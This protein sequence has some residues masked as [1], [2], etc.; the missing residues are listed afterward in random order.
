MRRQ[1]RRQGR[2]RRRACAD[3][4]GC[5]PRASSPRPTCAPARSLE[6]GRSRRQEAGDGHPAARLPDARRPTAAPRRRGRRPA[7]RA[8]TWSTRG[9]AD[10]RR[11]V[12]VVVTA[13][14]SYSRIKTALHGD[15]TSTRTSSCSS[16]SRASA[17]LDRYGSAVEH[18]AD[19]RLR[20]SIGEIYMVLEGENPTSMAKTTGLGLLEL[21]TVFDNLKPDVVVTVADRYETLATAVARRV[22]EHPARARAG[23]RGHRL[24]R[25]EGAPRRDEARRPAPRVD[26][27]GGRACHPHGRGAGRPC[28]VTGCPSIDLAAEVLD[29]AGARLRPVRALRR[30]R[31]AARP[32]A[33]ATSS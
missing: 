15:R 11:K 31:R 8:T 20:R 26:A 30:R 19:R 25:R 24:D 27:A 14:P 10:E 16:S 17:L 6:R 32:L 13:R 21:A 7:R 2:G 22:H 33:T 23:R 12:C 1:P 18:I 4:R 29:A 9:L 3:P 5:S 28:L